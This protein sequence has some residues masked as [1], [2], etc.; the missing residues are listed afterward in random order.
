M[1]LHTERKGGASWET[2]RTGSTEVFA[3]DDMWKNWNLTWCQCLLSLLQ[4]QFSG[5]L[6]HF[7]ISPLGAVQWAA[8]SGY[9][10]MECF[11][12]MLLPVSLV[13]PLKTLAPLVPKD[14]YSTPGS[15][16]LGR[17]QIRGLR[18]CRTCWPREPWDKKCC[19][20]IA[21]KDHTIYTS[22]WRWRVSK[23]VNCLSTSCL[24]MSSGN[25]GGLWCPMTHG[26]CR[27][28]HPK[29]SWASIIFTRIPEKISSLGL[30][31]LSGGT[32]GHKIFL[33]LYFCPLLL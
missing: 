4:R 14:A 12:Y 25:S 10:A 8:A 13:L 26:L 27:W 9:L 11:I 18:A 2:K 33:V 23:K 28:A 19:T 16:Q 31:W 7:P 22:S 20:A 32:S 29:G 1:K 17:S 30:S 21:E 3:K 6:C 24:G 5:L 15:R